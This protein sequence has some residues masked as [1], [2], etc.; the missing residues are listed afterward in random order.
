MLL[1]RQKAVQILFLI[2]KRETVLGVLSEFLLQGENLREEIDSGT[3]E[4]RESFLRK[5]ATELNALTHDLG[6]RIKHLLTNYKAL[7]KNFIYDGMDYRSIINYELTHLA[8]I[9]MLY[10]IDLDFKNPPERMGTNTS[11]SVATRD[12]YLNLSDDKFSVANMRKT[13]FDEISQKSKV[14]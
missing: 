3:K 8:K 5:K 4:E 1:C 10:G 6:M 7:G 2:E 14:D 12:H 13:M 11:R 9:L